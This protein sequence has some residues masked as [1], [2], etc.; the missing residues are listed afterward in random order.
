MDP[1]RQR[2]EIESGSS[3]L[4]RLLNVPMGPGGGEGRGRGGACA[5]QKREKPL[6]EEL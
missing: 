3:T 5:G 1:K 2:L 4:S 6:V